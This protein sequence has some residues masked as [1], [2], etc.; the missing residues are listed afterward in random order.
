MKTGIYHLALVAATVVCSFSTVLGQPVQSAA[1][2]SPQINPDHTVIFRFLAPK[3]G[4]VKLD[5]QF[6]KTP[7][8]MTKDAAGVW[9]VTVGPVHPDMY[10]Y[11]FIVDGV[12]VADPYNSAI[13]P[14]EGFQNSIVDIPG[15]QPLIHALQNVP[16][17][18]L[19]YRLYSS[20]ELGARPVVVYTPPGYEKNPGKKYPVLYLLHGTTDKEETWTKVG[21]A[22]IILDNLISQKKA[23]PMV[24][25][26]PYGRAYPIISTS[27]G[28]LRN[29]SNLQEIKKDFLNNLFPF[30][31]H[32]YRVRTDKQ[33]R[34]IAGFSGG[35]GT[36]LYLGLNHPE[37]F[38]WVCGFAPGML[39]EEFERN[40]EVAF[41]D[42]ALTNTRLNLFWIGVGKDDGL[43]PVITEYL[44]VLDE[45]QIHHETFISEGGHTWMNCK[46]FLSIIAQKLFQ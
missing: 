6:E 9:S 38:A 10:P 4:E 5:A 24:V 26:M 1:I 27:S 15:E 28:S 45:K 7:V 34:A 30:I 25:V 42:P 22:N 39:K 33:H 13:F 3:A 36:S 46:L 21:R 20:P 11:H 12:R 41:K 14:N 17:G 40:N 18:T 2:T 32:N 16:H 31:E 44:N 35:G 8:P 23:V 43:Y 19:S 37:L 29:W